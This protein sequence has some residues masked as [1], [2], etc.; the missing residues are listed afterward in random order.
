MPDLRDGRC[1]G[2]W[3]IWDETDDPALVEY[4]KH[5]CL[6]CPALAEC[7]DWFESLKPSHR[8][9]G[10]VAGKLVLQHRKAAA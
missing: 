6:S 8:P 3:S 4:A 2:Q 5:Q 1:R 9:I 7:K 10:T